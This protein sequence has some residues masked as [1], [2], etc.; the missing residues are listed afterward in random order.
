MS[1]KIHRNQGLEPI[2]AEIHVEDERGPQQVEVTFAIDPSVEK[3]A[4]ALY[5]QHYARGWQASEAV[6]VVA[7]TGYG[8]SHPGYGLRQ[9]RR[10]HAVL[11]GSVTLLQHLPLLY[12]KVYIIV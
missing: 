4:V 1:R 9:Q 7:H 3:L 5:R 2:F 12:N 6:G 8:R 11:G 10:V